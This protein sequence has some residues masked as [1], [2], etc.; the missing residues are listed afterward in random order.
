MNR[1]EIVWSIE[2]RV[3]TQKLLDTEKYPA[4]MQ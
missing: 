3:T 4:L 1:E 2:M